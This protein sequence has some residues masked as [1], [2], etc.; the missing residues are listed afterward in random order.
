[1]SCCEGV[2]LCVIRTNGERSVR[3]TTPVLEKQVIKGLELEYTT[4]TP[5]FLRA[6]HP[7]SLCTTKGT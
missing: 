4:H 1:M 7:L 5:A 2:R 3:E 6:C